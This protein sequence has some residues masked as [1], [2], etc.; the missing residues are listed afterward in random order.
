MNFD[1]LFG[2]HE[3]ALVLR[4][5]RAEVLAANLANADTPGYKSRDFDFKT[6][7][8]SEMD[9]SNRMRTTHNQHIQ[10]ESGPVPPSQL[11]YRTPMQPSMDGNTVDTE[12]EH[13][14]FSANAL[15]YQ[16]S[17]GF[18]NSKIDGIRKALRGE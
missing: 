5:Q 17:L 6:L 14:A 8:N 10:T 15:E 9:S 13:V 16:A 7:L 11:L 12:R 2:I 18:I 3:R 1:N 4:S